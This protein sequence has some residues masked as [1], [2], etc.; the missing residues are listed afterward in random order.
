L[1]GKEPLS[2]FIGKLRSLRRTTRRRG[3]KLMSLVAAGVK[4]V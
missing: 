4:D 1:E 2:C 3:S